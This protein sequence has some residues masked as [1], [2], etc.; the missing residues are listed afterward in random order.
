MV[1]C[2]VM[3]LGKL[4]PI[5][6]Y[7]FYNTNLTILQLSTA[8]LSTKVFY[9]YRPSGNINDMTP[10]KQSVTNLIGFEE[11]LSPAGAIFAVSDDKR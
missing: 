8:F 6:D 5:H 10:L 2:D 3:L 1:A 4:H 11:L 7:N 9:F